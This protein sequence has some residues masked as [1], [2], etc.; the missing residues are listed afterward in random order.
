MQSQLWP[1]A[2]HSGANR[3]SEFRHWASGKHRQRACDNDQA[4]HCDASD[5][6]A[7]T[8]GVGQMS[9]YVAAVLTTPHS[10]DGE[11]G[12]RTNRA[13]HRKRGGG[14]RAVLWVRVAGSRRLPH[15]A[16]LTNG[17]GRKKATSPTATSRNQGRRKTA[18]VGH[19]S[20]WSCFWEH[21]TSAALSSVYRGPD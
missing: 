20:G 19:R 9:S 4:D 6:A 3:C 14:R 10:S 1:A 16:A 21:G 8:M 12:S 18:P 2:L 7:N 5:E 11:S 15:I 17:G 13:G